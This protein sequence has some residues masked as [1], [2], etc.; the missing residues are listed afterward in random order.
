VIA[1]LVLLALLA[2]L[3]AIVNRLGDDPPLDYEH[4]ALTWS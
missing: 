4:P 3:V 2:S 1:G